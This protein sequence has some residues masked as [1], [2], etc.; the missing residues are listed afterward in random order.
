MPGYHHLHGVALTAEDEKLFGTT[1]ALATGVVKHQTDTN[2]SI[3]RLV[4]NI[5]TAENF[6]QVTMT[7]RLPLV[8]CIKL[9][10]FLFS[11]TACSYFILS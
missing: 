5:V 11:R 2:P 3:I 4:S 8:A 7:L 10:L 1:E 6:I 9:F